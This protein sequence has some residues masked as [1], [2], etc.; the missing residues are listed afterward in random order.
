MRSGYNGVTLFFILS[1]FVLAWSYAD[2]FFWSYTARLP[3]KGFSS[4]GNRGAAD[5]T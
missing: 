3:L 2:R 4:V 1:G 5:S